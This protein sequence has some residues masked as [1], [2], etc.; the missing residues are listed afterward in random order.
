MNNFV[1]KPYKK[2]SKR[3]LSLLGG[4]NVEVYARKTACSDMN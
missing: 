2:L 3:K 4:L 1:G